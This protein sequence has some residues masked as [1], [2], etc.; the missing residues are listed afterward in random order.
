MKYKPKLKEKKWRIE[1]E[2]KLIELAERE[3]LYEFDLESGRPIFSIDTPPPYASG[4]WHIAA[5]VHYTQID[6][7]ARS[8]RMRGYEVYF[9][10]GI[11]RNGLPVEV[12]AEK[13]T[14]IS[15]YTVDRGTFLRICRQVLDEYERDIIR[16]TRRLGLSCDYRNC[17]QTDSELWRT[18]T[19]RTLIEAYKKGLLYEA[20]RVSNYCPGCRTTLADAEI[21]YREEETNLVY[22]RFKVKE[23]SEPIVIATTR[24]ELLKACACVLYNPKDDRY[25]RLEGKHA[26][27]PVYG[28]EVPILPHPSVKKEFG[29]GLVMVCS[30]GDRTDVELFRELGLKP[31]VLINEEGKMN[32]EAGVYAGLR[33]EEA[34]ERITKDL[35][36][37]GFVEKVERIWHKIPICWRSKHPLEFIPMKEWYLKQLDFKDVLMKIAFEVK[38]YPEEHRQ[39][40]LNWINSLS[41][42]WPISRRRYYGTELPFWYCLECGMLVTPEPGR[43]YRPWCEPPPFDKCPHCGSTKGFQGEERVVDTWVDSSISELVYCGYGWNEE[44]LKRMF[45]CSIRPQGIDIVRTW[46]HY[47]MLRGYQLFGKPAFERVWLSGLG[48]DEKG[49]PMSKSLG[50]IVDPDVVIEKYGVDAIRLWGAMEAKLGSN[51]RY[52]EA[53]VRSAYRFLNKLWN[54]AR[55]VSCFPQAERPS[56]LAPADGWILAEL[57]ELIR[58]CLKGYDDLNFFIPANAI[59]NFVWNTYAPHYLEMVKWRAYGSPESELTKSAWYTLHTTLKAILLLLAPI[60]PFITDYIWRELYGGSIHKQLFPG[61]VEGID[62]G[63]R[64]LT[65]RIKEFNS[66]IWKLKK[67]E[68]KTPLNA[69][70]KVEI[71]PDLQML[72]DELT[73]MHNIQE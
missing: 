72:R 15:P 70:V 40:W 35:Q 27:V 67:I 44:M 43:Y 6:M 63:L 57:N 47:T 10:M 26:I 41:T 7:I 54:I 28:K 59:Y 1:L 3:N 39:L 71:P 56:K 46:L 60:T 13:K 5:A 9:P 16:L 37:A 66:Y 61:E 38:F 19:Q 12:E 30:Y 14:G 20:Y 29:S 4:K 52:S 68:L 65:D 64:R 53:K 21:E 36:E 51:Y 42:D 49:R 2:E 62:D 18:Q 11:D 50:N 58:V 73:H 45:P 48:L 8:M 34:R 25:M 55:F 17:F 32:E 22:I 33:V 24:P 31:L 69:P 23:T